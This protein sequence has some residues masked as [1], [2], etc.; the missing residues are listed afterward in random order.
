MQTE[1]EM[2]TLSLFGLAVLVGIL[3]GLGGL[4]L[5]FL[6]NF[7]LYFTFT[8]GIHVSFDGSTSHV[9]PSLWGMGIILVP[10]LG[11][12]IVTW[13]VH[14]VAP[15]T[16]GSGIP[17]VIFSIYYQKGIIRPI[18]AIVKTFA[19]SICMGTG[20]S[21]GREGPIVQVSATY[22]A[23]LGEK[24]IMAVEQRLILIAAGGAAGIA[25]AFNAP[26][27]GITFAIELLLI[28]IN[29]LSIGIVTTAVVAST[30][31]VY[32]LI[33][34]TSLFTFDIMT[35]QENLNLLIPTLLFCIPFGALLGILSAWFIYTIYW[36]EDLFVRFFKNPYIRHCTGMLGVGMLFYLFMVFYG[37]YYI[38]GVGYA[39]IQDIL[40]KL[41]L[42]PWLLLFLFLAK[43]VATSLTLSSGGS[44]GIFSPSLF[45]GACFGALF[46]ILVDHFFPSLNIDIIVFILAGMAGLTGGTTG[47][48]ITSILMIFEITQ[49][50]SN[51]LP[52]MFTASIAYIV[53]VYL[54][55]QSIY[56][57]KFYRK[58]YTL[59]QGLQSKFH[60]DK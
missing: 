27:A 57:L 5:R 50:Y 59:P 60:K 28:S 43:L 20:G 44:G 39:T 41:I 19:A 15:E 12:L 9:G 4:L 53:R 56:T 47:A 51:L 31:T 22:G 29:A 17:E 38:A 48:V 40:N 37:E 14:R 2:S 55:P 45:L 32:L 34:N 49:D 13:L 7:I 46:G 30:I 1:R 8:G 21:V 42:N 25:A 10:V 26:L 24:L 54:C 36:F 3:S 18:V 35:K 52:I 16:K 6:I 11:A 33:G 58:G 23:T